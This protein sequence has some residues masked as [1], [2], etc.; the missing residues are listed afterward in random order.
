MGILWSLRLE[1][2]R[3][4]LHPVQ[5]SANF[6]LEPATGPGVVGGACIVR[7]TGLPVEAASPGRGQGTGFG[8]EA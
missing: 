7:R 3:C 1:L 6:Y 4:Q 5:A 8:W 2:G